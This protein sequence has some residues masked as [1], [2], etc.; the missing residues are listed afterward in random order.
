MQEYPTVV[1]LDLDYTIWPC[2]CDTHVSMPFKPLSKSRVRDKY[3]EELSLYPE[4]ESI[5]LELAD[6]GITVVGASRTATPKVAK[7]LL[8][9]F[10]VGGK[11]AIKYFLSLQW[12]QGSKTKHIMKAAKELNLEDE[13]RD[14]EFILFDDESR[15]KDVETIG[16]KFAYLPSQTVGLSRKHFEKGINEW[17]TWR[18]RKKN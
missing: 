18:G 16:C 8:S 13:L 14:G 10:H 17:S 2:W 6:Q 7:E 3:G 5:I 1:V 4:V 15:N 11:P 12:G 9:L